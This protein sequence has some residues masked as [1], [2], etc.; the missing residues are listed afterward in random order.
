MAR[1]MG[2][3]VGHYTNGGHTDE[4]GHWHQSGFH[5]NWWGLSVLNEDEH[6]IA[7][8]DGTYEATL[9]VLSDDKLAC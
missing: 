2:R 7:P 6:G 4:C 8:D 3:L 9:C 1:Y 5:Y